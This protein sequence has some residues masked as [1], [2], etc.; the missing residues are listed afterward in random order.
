MR[1]SLKNLNF[2]RALQAKKFDYVV[3][4]AGSS[5]CVLAEKLS[6][7]PATNVLLLEAGKNDNYLPIHIPAGYLHCIM[8]PRSKF[9]DFAA[10]SQ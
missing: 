5:G 9:P 3:V 8:H 7:D 2:R 6:R 1:G 4:G 10:E